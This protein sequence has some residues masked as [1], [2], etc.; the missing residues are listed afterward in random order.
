[1][2]SCASSETANA[3]QHERRI[4]KL[5]YNDIYKFPLPDKHRFPMGKYKVVRERIQHDPQAG[6]NID[7]EPSP[8]AKQR[9]L[10][11]THCPEYIRRF[12]CNMLTERENRNIGFPWSPAGVKRAL[13]SVGGTVAAAHAVCGGRHMFSGHIAGG[14]HHAFYDYGEGF[15]VF[16]DIAVAANVVLR[17]YPDVERILIIDCDVHQGNGNA[18]LFSEDP[19][20]TT[21]SMHCEGN[22]FSQKQVSDFDVELPVGCSDERYLGELEIWLPRVMAFSRPQLIFFQAGVDPLGNDKMGKCNLSRDGLRERN[23]KVYAAAL[24]G[25]C[26]V[27][28]T[29]GGG[30]PKDLS[31]DSDD[32]CKVVAAH[33]DVY[34]QAAQALAAQESVSAG[35]VSGVA[36][37]AVLAPRV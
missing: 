3:M 31:E 24:E 20:V 37:A 19:R 13:S 22:Y 9:D 27:V 21:F 23:A 7:L 4:F 29:M 30:Y 12:L 10:L 11:V 1:M 14:T 5:F 8:L 2:R 18:V 36:L 16:S 34:L 28:V 15:C 6:K 33:T 17:D 35:D 26:K 25:Q 32:F